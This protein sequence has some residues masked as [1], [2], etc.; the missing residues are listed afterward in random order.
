MVL[1]SA[2]ADILTNAAETGDRD[3]GQAAA[4]SGQ[5]HT[6]GETI[7]LTKKAGVIKYAW[8]I[9]SCHGGCHL[10]SYIKKIANH[11]LALPNKPYKH[12]Q[13]LSNHQIS[14]FFS[15]SILE[16]H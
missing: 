10:V 7:K 15:T 14:R 1:V 12:P 4:D 9:R 5:D 8:H 16:C 3:V 2:P 11:L 6:Q 13:R